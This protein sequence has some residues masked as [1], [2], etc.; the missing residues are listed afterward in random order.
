ME[1]RAI[2]CILDF[3]RT[4]T[5]PEGADPEAIGIAIDCLSTAYSLDAT[6]DADL[7]RHG[8]QPGLLLRLLESGAQSQATAPGPSDEGK[9][10]QGEKGPTGASGGP[11]E[12]RLGDGGC[13]TDTSNLGALGSGESRPPEGAVDTPVQPGA[14]HDATIGN[15]A[16]SSATA[17]A[18]EPKP[19]SSGEA[20]ALNPGEAAASAVAS[21][22]AGSAAAAGSG[23]AVDVSA[24]LEEFL[25]GL[26]SAN[27]YDGTTPGS[28]EYLER[29]RQAKKIFYQCIEQQQQQEQQ[30]GV[31]L[32]KWRYCQGEWTGLV[33]P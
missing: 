26:E 18:P 32:G 27:Y 31:F 17:E 12:S 21:G 5:C 3:L 2:L 22:L 29:Q 25:K 7:S 8:V 1:R 33:S 19:S 24:K 23:G 28:W 9:Q 10:E 6:S 13:D 20:Q 15:G 11:A 16:K 14:P 4:A 30:V